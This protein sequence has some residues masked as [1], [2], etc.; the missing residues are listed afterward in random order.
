[1]ITIDQIIGKVKTY[2]PNIREEK[3]LEAYEFAKNCHKG[4]KRISGE[5][6]LAH[7]MAV[8]NIMMDFYPDESMIIATL[9]HDVTEDSVV[10]IDEIKAIYGS[11]VARLVDGMEK[12]SK[13]QAHGKDRQV[14]SLRKMFLAM[15]KDIRVVL[16]KLADRL[17]NMQTLHFVESKEKQKRIAEETLSIYAPIAA[18][19]GIYSIKGPLE[20]LAFFY[21]Q[22]EEYMNIAEQMKKHEPYSTRILKHAKK[23]LRKAMDE[24]GI[25]GEISGRVKHF[26]SIYKKLQRK[27]KDNIDD[28]YDIF[29]LRVILNDFKNCYIMLGRIHQQWTPLSKRFKDYIAVPKPNGYKSL[30]T[31]VI[32]LSGIKTRSMPIEIQIRTQKMQHEAEYGVAAHWKYKE[33]RPPSFERKGNIWIQH[34]VDIEKNAKNNIDFMQNLEIDTF[35]DRIFVLT[36]NGDVKDLPKDATPIDFA[37]AVHTD[38]GLRAK[39][40]K[41]N[42]AIVPLS[43][44]LENGSVIEVITSKK[45]E[46][47]QNWLT[48]VKTSAARNRIKRFLKSCNRE[49]I[50]RDGKNILNKQLIRFGMEELDPHLQ[51]LKN[52]GS[53]KNIP[54]RE[55]EEIIENIGNGTLNPTIIVK[56]IMDLMIDKKKKER[57][58]EEKE[59]FIKKEF[60]NSQILISGEKEI[61]IKFGKCCK[62]KEND[63]IVGFVTRGGH[64]TV[65]KLNCKTLQ[66]L[67]HHRLIEAR[68]SNELETKLIEFT[69]E[70]TDR[71]GL[72]RD[73]VDVFTKRNISIHKFSH[74][75]LTSVVDVVMVFQVKMNNLN[76]ISSIMDSLEEISGV[77]KVSQKIIE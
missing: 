37:F 12:L 55:R 49:K 27:N 21:L 24:E 76:I 58:Q 15:A 46:V 4:Q 8:L 5:D 75:K 23:E 34:L 43:H 30:H 25:E 63:L 1:M 60:Q 71:V 10:T 77:S 48:F 47:H 20:D 56:K 66:K 2:I 36:P 39:M 29:A 67:D 3:I 57:P 22:P 65:H 64:I 32:G 18:R 19:L 54:F 28:L 40:A 62:I 31:T 42:G 72:L 45:V 51:I 17:H 35:S 33:K 61:P 9:L 68:W 14:G 7:P 50:I 69:L 6:Y 11:T 59:K 13:V 41:V 73:V 70:A 53:K 38:V 44:H 74:A 52:I 26:Y 16:I